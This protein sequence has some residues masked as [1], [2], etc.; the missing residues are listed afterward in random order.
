MTSATLSEAGVSPTDRDHAAMQLAERK[1]TLLAIRDNDLVTPK[2]SAERAL[3]LS[4]HVQTLARDLAGPFPFQ[5]D[6]Y[7]EVLRLAK[8]ALLDD[9]LAYFAAAEAHEEHLEHAATPGD[10]TPA[11]PLLELVKSTLVLGEE[12]AADIVAADLSHRAYTFWAIDYDKVV[13]VGRFFAE[14]PETWPGAADV[15]SDIAWKT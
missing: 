2:V 15:E 14:V 4:A 10:E 6:F 3:E 9:A 1:P 11:R 13:R 7:N 8:G 12:S 5:A